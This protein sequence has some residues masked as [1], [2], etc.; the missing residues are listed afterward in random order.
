LASETRQLLAAR[1]PRRAGSSRATA[2][3]HW[4]TD[5]RGGVDNRR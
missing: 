1:Q 3:V 4:F 2:L 5:A